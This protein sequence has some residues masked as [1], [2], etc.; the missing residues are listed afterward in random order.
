MVYQK[1]EVYIEHLEG[2]VD[3]NKKKM[4]CKLKKALYRLKQAPREWYE[5]LHNYLEKIGFERKNYN[6]NII[7]EEW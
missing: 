6:S 2:F 5:G 4:V 7:F 3:P 1:K